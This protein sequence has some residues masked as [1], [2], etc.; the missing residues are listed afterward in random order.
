MRTFGNILWFFLA[1]IWLALGYAVAGILMFIT[2]I[3]IPFGIASF[4][5]AG[6]VL[7]PFGR[8]VVDKPGAGAPSMIGN[9]LWLIFG[10]LEMVLL[11]LIVGVVLC[12]TIIGIPLGII[13]F[14]MAN[15]AFLPLGREVVPMRDVA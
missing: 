4:R 5:L 3:G 15:L 9:I 7:W 14:K 10:G 11:H 1:G 13:S 12:V 8:T 6:Y 2:I